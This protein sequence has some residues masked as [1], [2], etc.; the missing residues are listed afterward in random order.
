MQRSVV[1]VFCSALKRIEIDSQ[2]GFL[3][4]CSLEPIPVH[5]NQMCRIMHKCFM[6]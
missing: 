6:H 3:S 5:I 2:T 4:R 1:S